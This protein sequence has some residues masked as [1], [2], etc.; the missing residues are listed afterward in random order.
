MKWWAPAP[1]AWLYDKLRG[2]GRRHRLMSVTRRTDRAI[3]SAT[4]ADVRATHQ[5]GVA[6]KQQQRVDR[7]KR[8]ADQYR[9]MEH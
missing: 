8:I 3:D 9:R 5:L 2:N 7:D 6:E 4:T 1:L